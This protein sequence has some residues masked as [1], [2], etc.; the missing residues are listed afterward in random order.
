MWNWSVLAYV[1]LMLIAGWIEGNNPAFTIVPGLM[2][3]VL[4]SLRLVT[5]I[6]ML[7]SSAEWLIAASALLGASGIVPSRSHEVTA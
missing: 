1:I 4:Y 3:N 5:G 2:R 7:I 6:F